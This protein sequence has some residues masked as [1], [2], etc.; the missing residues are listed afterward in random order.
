MPFV[1]VGA[2]RLKKPF[3]LHYQM[4]GNG[5]IKVLFIMGL[6]ISLQSWGEFQS[7]SWDIELWRWKSVVNT[8]SPSLGVHQISKTKTL[9]FP[10]FHRLPGKMAGRTGSA[11]KLRLCSMG[12]GAQVNPF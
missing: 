6:N 4:H 8:F 2:S 3:Q 10:L 7:E 9:Y 11:D 1:D 12:D 5:P